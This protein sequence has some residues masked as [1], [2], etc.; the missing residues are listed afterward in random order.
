[1]AS[2]LK[3]LARSALIY[4]R[5]KFTDPISRE[6]RF[7]RVIKQAEKNPLISNPRR[8]FSQ[9]DEDGILLNI[10]AR[11]EKESPGT[12]I[13][14]GVGDGR[15]NNTLILLA[16]GW[17]GVWI[18]A[19]D[20]CI[21][22]LGERLSFVKAWITRENATNLAESGLSS[23]QLDMNEVFLISV[24]IDGND[25]YVCD[26]LLKSGV[27]PTVFVVEF[28]GSFPPNVNFKIDYRG[29]FRGNGSDYYGASLG[30]WHE[31]FSRYD[32]FLVACNMTGSN[33]FFVNAKYTRVFQDLPRKIEE[34]YMPPNY[35]IFPEAWHWRSHETIE[36]IVQK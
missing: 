34:L 17:R 26:A 33:A 4:L 29:D 15:E 16:M 8:Y 6:L 13:E 35:E 14:F 11:I 21:S 30:A 25:Y 36:F 10:L 27:R 28:N 9:N 3:S 20:L 1:M 5:R 32:Y 22:R 2:R 19:E 7:S 23:L 31:L 12:F 18:G 24:D